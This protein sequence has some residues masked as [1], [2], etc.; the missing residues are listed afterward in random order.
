MIINIDPNIIDHEYLLVKKE[1]ISIIIN[2]LIK[3]FSNM[4]SVSN[5]FFILFKK[6]FNLFHDMEFLI[7]NDQNIKKYLPS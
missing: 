6:N 4:S 2:L 3:S 5:I 1:I 7:I